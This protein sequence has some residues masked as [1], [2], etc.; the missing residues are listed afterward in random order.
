M[1]YFHF[2]IRIPKQPWR[3][4]RFRITTILLMVAM[5]AM[6][7]AW[8][9]DHQRL[10]AEVNRLQYPGPNWQPVE[11]TGPP[12]TA[13]GDG[14]TAW[15][16]LTS[17]GQQEWLVLEYDTTVVPTAIIIHENL[18]PG[19]VRRVSHFPKFGIEQT[20][21]EGT[22]PT[23]ISAVSGVSRLPVAAGIKT[24]RIKIYLDS[25]AV[26]GWHEIDAVGL[27]SANAKT[28]WAANASAS[29]SYNEVSPNYSKWRSI[30]LAR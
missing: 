1:E 17:D 14:Q 7:L 2:T 24:N 21:W 20:L 19:A 15:C 16:H 13:A 26:P 4:I 28:I 9:R 18:G 23:P 30:S 27:V 11:A 6:A 29:S 5:L 12:N 8:W 25:P 22:D 10:S 3:W